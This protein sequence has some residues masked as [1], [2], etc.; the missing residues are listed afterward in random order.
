MAKKKIEEAPEFDVMISGKIRGFNIATREEADVLRNELS[1]QQEEINAV[2]KALK[3]QQTLIN[4]LNSK[5][6]RME[7]F[8]RSFK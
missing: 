2:K 1:R 4:I 3:E 7:N 8:L 5:L 6:D